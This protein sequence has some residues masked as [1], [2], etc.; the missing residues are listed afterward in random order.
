MNLRFFDFEVFPHWWCCVFGDLPNDWETNRPN[1]S[2]KN[3]FKVVR[4][5]M[6][7]PRDELIST[8]REEGYVQLGYNI[9]KYDLVIA[10]GVYQAFTPEQLK[11]LNDILIDPS[12]SYSTKEHMMIAPF[13][14][15][16]LG[17][18]TYQDLLDDSTGSLKEKE[19]VLGLNILESSVDFNDDNLN[20][21]KI[22]DIIYYCK[23]DVYAAMEFYMQI[24]HPYTKVKLAISKTF[25]ISE[26]TCYASTNSRL[27]TLVL[28][29]KRKEFADA[30]KIEITLPKRI[31]NYCRENVPYDILQH[32]LTKNTS[33]H[34]NLF[35]DEVDY[36]NGGIHSVIF[37]NCYIESDE[38]YMLVNVDA[39][40][41]YPSMLI[42][43]DCLSRCVENKQIFIDIYNERVRIK[44]LEHKTEADDEAQRAYKLVLNTTF[45]ASGNKWL[46]LYDPH[47]CTRTCRVGQIFLTALACKIHNTIDSARI[48][49]TNTDG[50]LVY[51]RRKDFCIMKKLT[52]EWTSVSG[53]N[54]EFDF[55]EKI[56]QRDVNNYLLV[57]E[58]GK[59][60]R[61]GGWLNTDYLR[62]GYVT[63]GSLSGIV[64][65]KAAQ[66]FLLHKTDIIKTI[67]ND[68]NIVD[69]VLSCTKGPSYSKVV[70]RLSNGCEVDLFKS[71]RVIATK[72]SHL[73]KIYKIKKYKDRLSYTQMAGIPDNCKLMNEAL[74]S[75]KME[76][77]RNELDYIFYIEKTM[78]LLDIDW[79][80]IDHGRTYKIDKFSIKI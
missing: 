34:T 72:D 26:K 50:I 2:L 48:I 36:G 6:G 14:K 58:G 56:W 42:Q 57:K 66:E 11:I 25:G 77:I 16:K 12:C 69:F 40:S 13:A 76:D 15:K 68:N 55:V 60:K 41:Y 59:V 64:C 46:D 28:K 19:C 75:Y 61:K 17:N 5:D 73:G 38:E 71:N 53:I 22:Q 18:V 31:D 29:A 79:Q 74:S 3:N 65:A 45:G 70:Q 80:Q 37:P 7:V 10:N 78:D 32:L 20:E 35:G 67:I 1:E 44:H 24:V 4:S 47:M 9:K 63:V 43:F 54:M 62:P 30:E 8:L 39:T 51:L 49:Q 27:V 23:Q 21:D 33:L 52:E